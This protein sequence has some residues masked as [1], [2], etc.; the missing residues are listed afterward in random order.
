MA[1]ICLAIT[2]GPVE[3]SGQGLDTGKIFEYDTRL[4]QIIIPV[5][6]WIELSHLGYWVCQAVILQWA[7]K[8]T[9]LGEGIDV[10]TVVNLLL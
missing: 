3:H 10:A 9:K 5:D 4:K 2:T 6:L 7:E 8:T 1:D